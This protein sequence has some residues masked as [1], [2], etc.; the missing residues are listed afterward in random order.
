[1]LDIQN[2]IEDIIKKHKTLA[3]IIFIH[4]YINRIDNRLVFKIK[5]G[6]RLELHTPETTKLFCN[7]KKL[8]GKINGENVEV[9]EVVLVQRNL[10]DNQYQQRS[11][12]LYTLTPNECFAYL[13][14]AKL[15]NLVVLKTYN[16]EFDE[17]IIT[18]TD[19]NGRPSEIEEK[20]YLTLLINK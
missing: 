14:N 8:I 9:V 15:S 4:V 16:T 11:E 2:Y 5:D 18:F 6:Y 12:V 10:V 7:T 17:I 13:V 3:K 1:M 20:V 19:Q